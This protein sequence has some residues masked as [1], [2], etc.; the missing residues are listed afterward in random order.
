MLWKISNNYSVNYS[1]FE[2]L[3]WLDM[4]QPCLRPSPLL[5]RFLSAVF[6]VLSF[7]C[8][9]LS[10][11]ICLK[12]M[13]LAINK[14]GFC[15]PDENFQMLEDFFI[16]L[17]SIIISRH[18]FCTSVNHFFSELG[19]W[20]FLSRS[21]LFNELYLDWIPINKLWPLKMVIMCWLNST[22]GK[23]S[24]VDTCHTPAMSPLLLIW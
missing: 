13:G 18:N 1:L 21:H 12:F 16:Y 7:I 11:C 3:L 2:L 17:L 20:S 22:V 6:P 10:S 15:L 9:H 14:N 5:H 19:P 24:V 8:L 23:I 4:Y